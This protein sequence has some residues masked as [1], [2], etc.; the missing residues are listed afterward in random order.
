[1]EKVTV[2]PE[3]GYLC[4]NELA[5][6]FNNKTGSNVTGSMRPLWAGFMRSAENFPQRPAIVA[7]KK[8]VSYG[9]LRDSARRI[10]ATIQ[11]YPEFS[12]TQLTAV[13]A[14]RS[15]TAFAGVLGTLLA[16]HG[17][18]PLNRTFPE[19]RTQVMFERSECRSLVVDAKS[20]PQ[21]SGIL[22]NAREPVL[23]ILPEVSDVAP[24][25]AK[26]PTHRFV[27]SEELRSASH[28]QEPSTEPGSLAYLL[29]TSGSTGTPKGVAVAQR[30][31]LAFLDYM[32]ARYEVTERDRLSQMFDM[33]F[34]L[35]VFDMFVAWE[36]GACVCC[37]SQKEMIKPDSYIRNNDLTIWFSVP[38]TAVF[39]KQLGL[40]KPGHYPNLRLSLFCGEPLP[41]SSVQTWSEA[42]PDSI[43]ENLY[44]P[45]ELTIACT[46]YRWNEQ[47][48]ADESERGIVPI[49]FPYPGMNYL[50]VDE[51]LREV[52]PGDEGELL[53]NGPQMSLGYWRDSKKTADAFITPPGQTEVY[54][55]TGDRVRRRRADGP[56]IHLGRIDSQIKVLGHR[57]ELG[58][59][60]AVVRKHCGSDAVVAAGWPITS[61]GYGGVEVFIEGHELGQQLRDAV[62]SDLPEYMAPRKFHFRDKLPRN[63]NGKLD[64]KAIA[65][66]LDEKSLDGKHD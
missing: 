45:T 2:L 14:Y 6:Q 5:A 61:S 35:S 25:E 54:Y 22:G 56:L 30:N 24:F 3:A 40:L 12:A 19:G 18:V 57:V 60:E 16:G 7:E 43:I 65:K 33:T 1:M 46:L 27:G 36:R 48:S 10:A 20:L 23:V 13:F 37:P 4:A 47:S 21:L 29:F 49:G 32:V 53:M 51:E 64:R 66:S 11:S 31:V 9:D 44:G 41:M 39:M 62:R 28:W 63:S 8:I 38:S 26:W 52:A 59:I 34:D 17:Y 58:E 55:R 42:A 50:V 15:P